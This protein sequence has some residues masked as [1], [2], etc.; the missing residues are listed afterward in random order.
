MFC[1]RLISGKNK[2]SSVL[3][4]SSVEGNWA[5]ACQICGVHNVSSGGDGGQMWEHSPRNLYSL[6][7]MFDACFMY[8]VWDITMY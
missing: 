6:W 7:G 4:F 3:I 5:S 2:P 8:D 1:K